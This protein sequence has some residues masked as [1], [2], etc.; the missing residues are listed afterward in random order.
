M[1]FKTLFQNTHAGFLSV[2]RAVAMGVLATIVAGGG[3][4][5]TYRVWD[6]RDT[7]GA[8]PNTVYAK[9]VLDGERWA[10]THL[11]RSDHDGGRHGEKIL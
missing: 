5:G 1:N 6:T 4:Y 8:N 9:E 7:S 10:G 11:A 3:V 2:S